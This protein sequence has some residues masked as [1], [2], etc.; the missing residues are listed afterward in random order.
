MALRW[1]VSAVLLGVSPCLP[2]TDGLRVAEDS[3]PQ[4]LGPRDLGPPEG[5][6]PVADGG[7][8]DSGV[9]P[10]GG[11]PATTRVD[12]LCDQPWTEVGA[13]PDPNCRGRLVRSVEE[14]AVLPWDVAITGTASGDL[15]IAWNTNAFS[16]EG[17]L[18]LRRLDGATLSVEHAETL[19]GILGE[20]VGYRVALDA[21]GETIQVGW[22]TRSDGSEIL[23]ARWAEDG[24]FEVP[25]VLASDVGIT[26]DLA[27]AAA[28][29]GDVHVTYHDVITGRHRSRTRRAAGGLSPVFALDEDLS[30]AGAGYGATAVVLHDGVLHAGWQQLAAPDASR[31]FTR[32]F[33]DVWSQVTEV[34][35]DDLRATGIGLAMTVVEGAPVAAYLVWGDGSAEVRVARAEPGRALAV[36]I[37]I[38]SFTLEEAPGDYP[39]ALEADPLGLLHLVVVTPISASNNRLEYHRQTV[40]DGTWVVDTVATGLAGEPNET[41]V[42]LHVGPDRRPHIVYTQGRDIEYA[43]IELP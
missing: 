20:V 3:G 5:G 17:S 4:D 2:S 31:V 25:A 23:H 32:R 1:L 30:S 40:P 35:G 15:A 34:D 24:G 7:P 41:R 28:P 21:T 10:D 33:T 22:W 6:L 26:G 43:T 11:P 27:L 13:E 42:A 14:D 16:D 29:N 38:R 8:D 39:I 37:R 12:L 9:A 19:S 36:D 18:E